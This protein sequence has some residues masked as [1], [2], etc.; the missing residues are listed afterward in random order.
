[1]SWLDYKLPPE[2][3]VLINPGSYRVQDVLEHRRYRTQQ[4]RDTITSQQKLIK[5]SCERNCAG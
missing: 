4:W 5:D 3:I 2:P 1:M